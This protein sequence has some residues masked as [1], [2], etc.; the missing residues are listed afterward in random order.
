[1]EHKNLLLLL[2]PLC[3][4]ILVLAYGHNRSVEQLPAG[5]HADQILENPAYEGSSLI[6]E[7]PMASDADALIL[8]NSAYDGTA[9]LF[10]NPMASVSGDQIPGNLVYGGS[11]NTKIKI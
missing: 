8:G 1:M 9:L 2:I 7:N 5:I 6:F 10:E 4:C 11:I 3:F